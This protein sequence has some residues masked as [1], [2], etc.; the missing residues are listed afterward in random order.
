MNMDIQAY[1]VN[2]PKRHTGSLPSLP[3][4]RAA[5]ILL[6]LWLVRGHDRLYYE[7]GKT[8][9]TGGLVKVTCPGYGLG[10]CERSRIPHGYGKKYYEKGV[11]WYEG[12]WNYGMRQGFGKSF[13]PGGR[14]EY[15]GEWMN[16]RWHGRGKVYRNDGTL[17]LEGEFENDLL[18]GYG[19][20]YYADGKPEYEGTWKNGIWHGTQSYWKNSMRAVRRTLVRPPNGDSYYPDETGLRRR[21]TAGKFSGGLYDRNRVLYYE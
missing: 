10:R 9:Y 21:W 16:N 20:S 18:N 14:V 13:Y 7:S 12:E 5:F 1:S 11:L 15:E 2:I 8:A 17:L 19:R 4:R 6:I 3:L